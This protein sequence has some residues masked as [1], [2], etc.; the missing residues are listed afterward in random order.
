MAHVIPEL[1]LSFRILDLSFLAWGLGDVSL[2]IWNWVLLQGYVL[3]LYP[4][5]AAF[6][7]NQFSSYRLPCPVWGV[8]YLAYILYLLY[9]PVAAMFEAQLMPI[10]SVI[11]ACE[12]VK[13]G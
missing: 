3:L 9:F 7:S 8:V 5:F 12:Q 2:L 6:T 11:L 4:L 13:S 1:F 10:A